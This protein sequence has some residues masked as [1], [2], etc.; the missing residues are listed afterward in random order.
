MRLTALRPWPENLVSNRQRC[1]RD[2]PAAQPAGRHNGLND[3]DN[4]F[5]ACPVID[6]S[7]SQGRPAS[8]CRRRQHDVAGLLKIRRDGGLHRIVPGPISET[9][10]I[11][12]HRR[13]TFQQRISINRLRQRTRQGAARSA[14][15]PSRSAPCNVLSVIQTLSALNPRDSSGPR[16]TGQGSPAARPRASRRR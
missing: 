7:R 5:R 1:S 3:R 4:V 6:E 9:D 13:Q 10:D 15:R 11:E 14:T 12:R 2:H 16:S 8:N